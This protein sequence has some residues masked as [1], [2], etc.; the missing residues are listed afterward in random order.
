M[1]AATGAG[2]AEVA[3]GAAE[4]VAGVNAGSAD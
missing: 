3:A 4:V 1:N 2:G